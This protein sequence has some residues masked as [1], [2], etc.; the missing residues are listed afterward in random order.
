MKLSTVRQLDQWMT[1]NCYSD[2]YAIGNRI[3]H[4]GYGLD[5]LDSQYIWYYTERGERQTLHYFLTEQEA[6]DFA[7]KKIMADRF[8]NRHL[9]GFIKDKASETELVAELGRRNVAFWKDD[10]PYGGLTD[11]R[12]RVFVFGCDIERV[13]DLQTKYDIRS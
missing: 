9:V 8:A 12:T 13:L 4:E 1:E 10:I 7:F 3:I 6:V 5:K 2:T 11:R